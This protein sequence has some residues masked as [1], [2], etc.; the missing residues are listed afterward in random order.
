MGIKKNAKVLGCTF[1]AI[2]LI[3]GCL[4]IA[5]SSHV[6]ELQYEIDGYK[7]QSMTAQ[8]YKSY[9]MS[10]GIDASHQSII[11]A[12]EVIRYSEEYYIAAIAR[13]DEAIALDEHEK[14]VERLERET[15]RDTE[16]LDLRDKL[17]SNDITTEE[18]LR[19]QE[20][21]TDKIND[22]STSEGDGNQP[23]KPE[24]ASSSNVKHDDDTSANTSQI[25]TNTEAEEV[26][27]EIIQKLEELLYTYN[28]EDNISNGGGLLEGLEDKD[29]GVGD[30]QQ[31][32]ESNP[33]EVKVPTREEED[34][35]GPPIE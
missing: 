4:G 28:P 31:E 8:D 7:L 22:V 33:T 34:V 12:D 15:A 29:I 32:Q 5:S 25:L 23:E 26:I 9:A 27:I 30:I 20:L 19:L 18:L 21:I 17:I 1:L 3:A 11:R 14:E 10:R 16:I 6:E 13:T 2:G 35:T 24:P